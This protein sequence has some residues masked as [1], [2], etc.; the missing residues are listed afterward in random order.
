MLV[1]AVLAAHAVRR[2]QI[3]STRE[4]RKP[5]EQG[6]LGLGQQPVG[7]V[8]RRGDALLPRLRAARTTAKQTQSV[9]ASGDVEAAHHSH[10]G[11]CQL[12]R[13]GQAV[14]LS[15]DLSHRSHRLTVKVEVR[16][17]CPRA[18]REQRGGVLDRQW[19]NREYLFTLDAQRF[20]AGGQHRYPG[21]VLD[22]LVD[23]PRAWVK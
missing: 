20:A 8:N 15:T 1:C 17:A 16:A 19:R 5:C 13:Q 18:V 4:H 9:Q 12:D 22:D 7:P 14:E 6:P 10:S 21:T 2:V 3:E 11:R 23:Q